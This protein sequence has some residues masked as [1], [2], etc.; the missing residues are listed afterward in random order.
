MAEHPSIIPG[1]C[2]YPACFAFIDIRQYFRKVRRT[3][4]CSSAACLYLFSKSYFLHG[5]YINEMLSALS[6]YKYTDPCILTFSRSYCIVQ[7]DMTSGNM[8]A[9]LHNHSTA[10]DGEYS[11]SELVLNAR[12]A[13]LRAIALT[14]HDT[15]SGIDEAMQAGID[16]GIQVIPGIEVSLRF[17][18]TSFVGTLHMLLYFP[19]NL[20]KDRDFQREL[21]EITGQGR[22]NALV[23][24]RVNAINREFGPDGKEPLLKRALTLEEVMAQGDN[25]TRRHF[26]LCLS[27]DHGITD[28]TITD[29]IL[30]NSSPAYIPSGIDMGLLKP[31][32]AKYPV[33]KVLAHP[34]AGSWPEESHYKEVLPPVSTVEQLLPEF[35]DLGLDGIEVYYP[36]HTEAL[37]EMLRQWADKHDLIITGGSDCHD[38]TQRPPAVTGITQGEFEVFMQR[39]G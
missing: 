17:I 29:R 23:R 5:A 4:L 13:G 11:P 14:D 37:Q 6:K 28:R 26:F 18:R 9:D 36:A 1:A 34:A 16:A 12:E 35:L 22:G 30:G 32:F 33:I 21:S 10:S 31:L 25:I 2:N 3:Q 20:A 8:V 39:L 15:I 38:S 24:D 7:S 19:A 27:R